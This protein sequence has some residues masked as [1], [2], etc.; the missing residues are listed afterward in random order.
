MVIIF[1]NV[2]RQ[3]TMLQ[4][5][6][7][8]LADRNLLLAEIRI[9]FF[10]DHV[11]WSQH[12]AALLKKSD[13]VIFLWQGPVYECELSAKAFQL[14]DSENRCLYA[15][16]STADS[17]ADRINGFR[18]EEIK[19]IRDYILFSGSSNYQNLLLWLNHKTGREACAYQPPQALAWQGLYQPQAREKDGLL[20]TAEYVN[21]FCRQN[22]PLV[23][24]LFSRESWIWQDTAY[25]DAIIS[26]LAGR[27]LAALPVFGLWEDNQ[28][29]AAAGISRAVEKF[30][31]RQHEVIIAAVI[32]TFKVSLTTS[33]Q[34]Q[35]GFLAKLNVPVIQAYNLLR[36]QAEW[37]AGFVGLNPVELSVN[38]VQPEFDGIIH[39]GVVSSKE[40]G[41]YG[42]SRYLPV[43]E[44][45]TA[46]AGKVEKWAK[47]RYSD[48]AR[49]KVA[50]IFHNYP[51]TNANI[52]NAQGLDSPASVA[53]LLQAMAANGYRIDTLPASG[54][55]LMADL[56]AGVTNDRRFL[57]DEQLQ[58][59]AGKVRQDDY[60]NWFAGLAPATRDELIREWG[61]PPGD[62]FFAK[63]SL[64]V[65]GKINGNIL[66]TVQPPRGFGEDAGKIL[67]SPTCPPPHHY[68]AFYTWI[69]DV[70]Q[71]DAVIH[72]GTHG[73]LEWLPGK[74][75]GLAPT[76]YPELALQSLPNIYPYYVTIVGEGIQA[77]RRG[78]A[79]LIGHLCPPVSQAGTYEEL[80]E[81]DV[82]LDEYAHYKTTQSAGAVLVL[83]QIET[84]ITSLHLAEDVPRLAGELSDDYILRVHM[85]LEN[86]KHM[87][88]RAGLHTL[89]QAP[90]A[91]NLTEY[92]LALTRVANG[93][94]PS[95]P[96][97]LA[98]AYGY[99]Y[100]QLIE[101]S[102]ELVPDGNCT[103]AELADVIWH[104]CRVIVE[105]LQANQFAET[106]VVEVFKLPQLRELN[107]TGTATGDLTLVLR[108][109]CGE[110]SVKLAATAQEIT[111]TLRALHGEYVEPGPGGAPTNGRADILPT[112]RNFYGTDPGNLPTPAAWEIGK[113]LAEQVLCRYIAEEGVYPE[114]IGMVMWSDSNM[115][116]N[117]QCL[118]ELLYL[119]GVRP[120]W[121]QGSR[122]VTGVEVIELRELKRPRIDVLARVSGL[123]R[124][125]LF[126][127]IQLM[128]KATALVAALDE[129]AEMNFVRKHMK[130]DSAALAAQGVD[131]DL[132]W[133][134]A[135]Y[136]IFGCPPGGY[137]AG[138]AALLEARSWE[139]VHDL[140]DVYVRW[141]A[142]AYGAGRQGE[143]LPHLF[144]Q[145]LGT[146]DI[147]IKNIDNHEVHLLSSDD[148][149]AYCGGMNAA[150]RSIRGRAPRCYIGDS[151]DQS[152][153]ETR[154]LGEEF[155]RVL[156]G[157]SLNPKFIEGMK[158][159]G[160]KGAAD[161]AALVCHC[162]GWDATSEVM[163]DWMYES[164]AAKLAL[165]NSIQ[166]WMQAV[167]PWALQRLA[168][169]LLEAE[170]RGLWQAEPATKQELERLYL[171]IEGELEERADP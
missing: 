152:H 134:Q 127:A 29:L 65:P 159:H 148:F 83:E 69:R 143:F 108:Y 24:I 74:N 34:N 109:I 99:D 10:N 14:L 13:T 64:L 98:R 2:E 130:Q 157:E 141:G 33:R 45:V 77:K 171:A 156:R 126:N 106:A 100:Y 116:T 56:V 60:R 31:Y 125:T 67:H 62:V 8:Y 7:R 50:I 147:T 39:G 37:Q 118:A 15:F 54:C 17:T 137:G 11:A 162:L 119:L 12:Y 19:Q 88:I 21:A 132:A 46:L 122:R 111:N 79:C 160:Y 71:A 81:L 161:L 124:D 18:A 169:K 142:H 104:T 101:K 1:T 167:N 52:G 165:D 166:Q 42:E 91:E 26:E 155:R 145:R 9:F 20:S 55:E 103:Y 123:F 51:P 94:V 58:R 121:Q 80:A 135:G 25:I 95:L 128:E 133:Q 117:G 97:V 16:M 48:N 43:Q 72:V 6:G 144:R 150:V 85:Y 136:R 89:G 92:I 41:S 154:S 158:K 75:A 170:R 163:R 68:F 5:A 78:A 110:L 28:E 105:Y 113:T 84:K 38:I 30:F 76:C 49:K 82:L 70:W 86:L 153:T 35:T 93:S 59:V 40:A 107:L 102:G 114:S 90:Q 32:N 23:G 151:T 112:G 168:E 36:S 129:P 146:L 57:T 96:Q 61:L 63:D 27:G 4:Q 139:N 115:R 140:A 53:A 120:V 164:L 22:R 3:W 66:I 131:H 138:V 47:L 44:R 87:Q 73:S 149:N